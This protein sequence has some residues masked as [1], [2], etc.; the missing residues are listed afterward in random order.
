MSNRCPDFDRK[1]KPAIGGEHRL[2]ATVGRPAEY[3][4]FGKYAGG[5]FLCSRRSTAPT[6][7]AAR[8]DTG[9]EMRAYWPFIAFT[10]ICCSHAAHAK[11]IDYSGLGLNT[12]QIAALRLSQA[13]EDAEDRASF[14]ELWA[15]APAGLREVNLPR[16][17]WFAIYKWS[18]TMSTIGMCSRF[19]G[20]DEVEGMR[21]SWD[22]VKGRSPYLDGVLEA[23]DRAFQ[24]GDARGNDPGSP[25]FLTC[26]VTF[27]SLEASVDDALNTLDADLDARAKH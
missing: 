6:V 16:S 8:S 18:I 21:H 19:L 14:D 20:R 7:G 1:G 13:K 9:P 15:T 17:G 5:V 10:L 23:A 4:T 11:Q 27:R 26:A 25:D 12:K 24:R 3:N 2:S 22:A